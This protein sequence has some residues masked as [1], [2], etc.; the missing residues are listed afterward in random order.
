MG[1]AILQ[2]IIPILAQKGH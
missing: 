1:E 2:G